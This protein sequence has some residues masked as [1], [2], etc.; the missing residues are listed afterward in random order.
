MG[1][2]VRAQHAQ[3]ER[4]GRRPLPVPVPGPEED[5]QPQQGAEGHDDSSDERRD[6]RDSRLVMHLGGPPWEKSVASHR[7]ENAGLAVLKYEQHSSERNH[8]AERDDPAH[9]RETRHGERFRERIGR[10]E[11]LV[12]HHARRNH[13]D[14]DV[15][16]GAD[17]Q[18]AQNAN[19]KISLRIFH[20][21][22]RVGNVVPGIR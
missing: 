17:C 16:H 3:K 8:S 21:A 18:P 19:R 22:S 1:E 13:S 20:F 7:E 11:L 6:V 10:L 4:E 9:R 12:R 5:R 2:H 14:N 15:N